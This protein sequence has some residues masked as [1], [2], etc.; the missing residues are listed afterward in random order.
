MQIDTLAF[1]MAAEMIFL[2]GV[3]GMSVMA[4]VSILKR[5]LKAQGVA[6][7]IISIVVAAGATL[8]YL[9][10][11]GFVLWKF[12]VYTALVACAANGIYLFPQ[13]RTA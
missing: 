8:T 1:L 10:P 12:L 3:A 6:V 9:I 7:I 4:L 2:T 11:V 5:L 13:K